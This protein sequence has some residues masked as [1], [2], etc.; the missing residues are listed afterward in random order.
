MNLIT[1]RVAIWL[2]STKQVL[3]LWLE[4]FTLFLP[5]LSRSECIDAS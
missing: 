1:T 3:Q 5:H 2:V 4:C